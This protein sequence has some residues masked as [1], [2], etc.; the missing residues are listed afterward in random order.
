MPKA[1]PVQT[2]FTGGEIAPGLMG[3]IDQARYANACLRLENWIPLPQGGVTR[4]PGIRRFG[5]VQ[6]GM[7]SAYNNVI[8]PFVFNKDPEQ[9]YIIDIGNDPVEGTYVDIYN[10]ATDNT[11]QAVYRI[12]ADGTRYAWNGSALAA[13]GLV[14][15]APPWSNAHLPNLRWKQTGDVLYLLCKVGVGETGYRVHKLIR[16]GDTQPGQW[17]LMDVVFVGKV[18][19]IKNTIK[20][21]I[22]YINHDDFT[23]LKANETSSAAFTGFFEEQP[24]LV[25]LYDVVE[26]NSGAYPMIVGNPAST[27]YNNLGNELYDYIINDQTLFNYMTKDGQA[28]DVSIKI[29]SNIWIPEAGTYYFAVNGDS[30]CDLYAGENY[31]SVAAHVDDWHEA[32]PMD[33]TEFTKSGSIVLSKG[34]H[35]LLARLFV[36]GRFGYR[37]AGGSGSTWGISV[38]WRKG[39]DPEYGPAGVWA[40]ANGEGNNALSVTE[41]WQGNE[42]YEIELECTSSTEFSWR[43][44]DITDFDPMTYGDWVDVGTENFTT[45]DNPLQDFADV[46]WAATSGFTIGDKWRFRVGYLPIPMKQFRNQESTETQDDYP[47]V[48]EFFQQRLVLSGYPNFPGLIRMSKTA[49]YENFV[50]GANPDDA[51]EIFL[52]SGQADPVQGLA[53]FRDLLVLTASTVYRVGATN[54]IVMPE[55]VYAKPVSAIGGKFVDPVKAGRLVMFTDLHGRRVY[56][57]TWNEFDVLQFPDLSIWSYH[58]LSEGVKQLAY[59]QT[60]I[61]DWSGVPVQIV[62]VITEQGHLRFMVHEPDHQVMA[63]GRLTSYNPAGDTEVEFLGMA[64]IPG[65]S[66]DDLWLLYAMDGN[67]YLGF[68]TPDY[69]YDHYPMTYEDFTPYIYTCT[70]KP[71]RLAVGLGETPGRVLQK[72]RNKVWLELLSTYRLKV[73]GVTLPNV[74]S[75]EVPELVEQLLYGYDRNADLEIVSDTAYRATVLSLTSKVILNAL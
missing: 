36:S 48:L 4:R 45:T 20:A 54:D 49:D 25:S 28:Y 3:R 52:S 56:G 68:L 34:S 38:A 57:M 23:R 53:T 9:S 33:S 46:R 6:N 69:L 35:P 73:N 74:T 7:D 55:D 14:T 26:I 71:V 60:A 18:Y 13:D 65:S 17:D 42:C 22:Y 61:M 27:A 31:E 58:L 29:A 51:L 16:S 37:G 43:Y 59:Q 39:G 19:D 5:A 10:T 12:K 72:R 50:I 41:I 63:W 8:I 66:G 40:G 47:T 15:N 30:K 64:V 70:L 32:F 62:W 2:N 44:R 75:T 24:N 11:G 67:K 1:M 21:T